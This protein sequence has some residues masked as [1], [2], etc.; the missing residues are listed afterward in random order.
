ME[1]R[2]SSIHHII[3]L[4]LGLASLAAGVLVFFNTGA[5]L[6]IGPFFVGIL[7]LALAFGT[8]AL[9][10]ASATTAALVVAFAIT[11]IDLGLNSI[12]SIP[13]A[14]KGFAYTATSL[15]GIRYLF[16]TPKLQK[17]LGLAL[18]FYA[19]LAWL[20]VMIAAEPVGLLHTGFALFALGCC[21]LTLERIDP[22]TA[23]RTV[24]WLGMM[25]GLACLASLA[26]YLALP[27]LAIATN[28]AGTGRTG[29]IFGS[30]NSFGAVAAVGVLAGLSA[31]Y[32]RRARVISLFWTSLFT[33]LSLAGL[34]LSGSRTAFVAL[35]LTVA[36]TAALR[37]L[38]ISLVLFAIIAAILFVVELLYGLDSVILAI[39][40]AMARNPRGNDVRTLTGRLQIWEF[41][42][43]QWLTQ[44]WFGFGLGESRNVISLG[45]SNYWGGTTG[46]A[47]N[48]VL[49]SLLN[50]GIVGTALLLAI[51]SR[52]AWLIF[53]GLR[54]LDNNRY[55]DASLI[56]FG[57]L[58]FPLLQGIT[59]KSF[60][61]TASMSTGALVLA[62]ALAGQSRRAGQ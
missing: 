51:V 10:G 2:A 28:V 30:P 61:G 18:T 35:A 43:A 22:D 34:Y 27:G 19:L 40:N 50:V 53:F 33:M 55:A 1:K 52:T 60:G 17:S 44:P 8:F 48:L 62:V 42:Y 26:F 3:A 15:I 32:F 29:G 31:M 57:M 7:A 39:E 24:G 12:G 13:L 45:W 9:W 20:T 41:S 14:I 36:L 11:C 46:S 21:A 58:M 47:H 49:E 6:L 56:A 4:I 38:K 37:R 54:R 25:I 59:E 5:T 23:I 16:G